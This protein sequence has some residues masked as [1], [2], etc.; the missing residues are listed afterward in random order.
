[1]VHKK[2]SLN[3]VFLDFL[4]SLRCNIKCIKQVV[5]NSEIILEINGYKCNLLKY[6]YCFSRN[7]DRE[8]RP[9]TGV[10][11]GNIY[12]EMESNGSN[13]I[14]DMMLVDTDRQRPA[15]FSHAEPFP[16]WGKILHS[17]DD[18][19][20]RELSFDEAYLYCYDE[21]MNATESS[22]MLTRFL[23][24]PTRL[25]INRTIRLDRRIN[26]TDG[27][28]WEECKEEERIVINVNNEP[29][30]E[31]ENFP[32]CTVSFRRNKD[33]DGSFGF[34]WLR[35]GDTGEIGCDWYRNTMHDKRTYD[36]FVSSEYKYFIQQWR[37]AIDAYKTTSHYIIP[38]VTLPKGNTATFR[39]KMEV[40]KPSGIL[41][42]KIV[43]NG[44]NALS[45]NLEEIEAEKTGN[46]YYPSLLK[47]KCNSNFSEQTALEVRAKGELVG[48][49]IFIPNNK[50]YHLD[51][52]IV[53]I[54]T[55][56]LQGQIISKKPDDVVLEGIKRLLQQAYIVPHFSFYQLDLSHPVECELMEGK[57]RII[58]IEKISGEKEK[59][60]FINKN[61]L[62]P[63]FNLLWRNKNGIYTAVG[64]GMKYFNNIHNFLNKKLYYDYKVEKQK[65]ENMFK[66]Y[67]FD[68]RIFTG[69]YV[70]GVAR[71]ETKA[72][73]I[74]DTGYKAT[75]VT[76]ELLH[77]LS[78]EHPF[79]EESKYLFKKSSTENLMDYDEDENNIDDRKSLW[80]WQIRQ[81]WNQLK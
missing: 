38:W 72:A 10:L 69:T 67:F 30:I 8:G 55:K 63:L 52:A 12:I 6:K 61:I 21:I 65:L 40:N 28:W 79:V 70:A 74:S 66:I 19:M 14:L 44:A 31:K 46:Y 56:T 2:C 49:M 11:G 33:Y 51:I 80:Y 68:E 4:L 47:V 58:E 45:A 76:H 73:C 26:T 60:I 48:K 36:H 81:I 7:I 59:D 43:G 29:N 57:N 35:V 75:T 71:P 20:F 27:F 3:I 54:K 41:D 77:L 32:E 25:D 78:L 13:C 34:D 5:M 64:R 24:S 42:I 53:T 37:K 1:M 22:P 23:I 62:E 15:F 9:V 16:V 39:M 50:L 17:I 18:M